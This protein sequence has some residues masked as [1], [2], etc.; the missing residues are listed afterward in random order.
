MLALVIAIAGGS[1]AGYALRRERLTPE[2]AGNRYVDQYRLEGDGIGRLTFGQSPKTVAAGLER[3]LGRP[4]SASA[5]PP[6][7]ATFAASDADSTT[8]SF[9]RGS[10]Q[11]PAV[12]TPMA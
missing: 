10:P 12:L 4:A 11:S 3:L 1:I 8:R 2:S 7:S 6:P 9:G 5:Q